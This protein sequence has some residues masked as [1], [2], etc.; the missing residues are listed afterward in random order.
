MV[1]DGVYIKDPAYFE[2][3]SVGTNFTSNATSTGTTI[4]IDLFISSE[5]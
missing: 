4:A 2:C 5:G 1:R 3:I